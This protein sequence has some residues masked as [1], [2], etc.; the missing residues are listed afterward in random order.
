MTTQSWFD[1]DQVFKAFDRYEH[2]IGTPYAELCQ[3]LQARFDAEQ[4]TA[5]GQARVAAL[6]DRL[7]P[8]LAR[9][10]EP[11]LTRAISE[12]FP[13]VFHLEQLLL[14]LSMSRPEFTAEAVEPVGLDAA[15]ACVAEGGILVMPHQ[16]PHF[17]SHLILPLLGIH[18]F[19]AG[20]I[21][22]PMTA[23]MQRACAVHGIDL[24][25]LTSV[26]FTANFKLALMELLA[27]GR[28]VTLY[29][30]YSRSTRIGSATTRFL[31]HEVHLPTGIGRLAQGF[32]R[33]MLG[34]RMRRVAPYRY[35]L[36][37][38]PR[39]EAPADEAE[40]VP[41]MRRVLAWVEDA[42]SE[43]RLSW[44]GWRTFGRMKDNGVKALVRQFAELRTGARISA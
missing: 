43:D 5:E 44:E 13:Q 11:G 9:F 36:V 26:D 6:A 7:T 12:R 3:Q 23:G 41:T 8:D 42:V 33:P 28:S 32:Q 38:G 16:G 27:S 30:E 19:G 37:F 22:G 1:P 40:I 25:D 4:A 2:L 31:E 24:G 18:S 34:V 20:S 14:A 10:D 39:W 17:V 29:P 15:R 21:T 35:Q